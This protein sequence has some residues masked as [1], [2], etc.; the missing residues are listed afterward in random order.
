VRLLLDT[1]TLLWWR[2]DSPRLSS[3]A[4]SEIADA[5]NE[6]LVSVATLWEISIKRVLGK[7]SFPDDLE[8]VVREESFGLV[9]ISF[10]HPRRL[11][12]LPG[13]HRDPFDRMLVAQALTEGAPLVT[14]DRALLAYGAPTLW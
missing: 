4:R 11:E 1:H 2:D 6:I 3:R 5:T 10:Q 9:P 8:E 12:T 14:N 7:L 13:L